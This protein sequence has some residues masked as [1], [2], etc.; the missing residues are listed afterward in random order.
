MKNFLFQVNQIRKGFHYLILL[1]ITLSLTAFVMQ[2]CNKNED[3]YSDSKTF[4]ND[5]LKVEFKTTAKSIVNKNQSTK[6]LDLNNMTD[7]E[8]EQLAQTSLLLIKS[9]GLTESEIEVELEGITN[10]KLIESAMAIIAIEE[11]ASNNLE[12]IDVSDN[13]SLLTGLSVIPSTN[14]QNKSE[15]FHCAMEAIG[16]N[17]LGELISNGIRD[18]PKSAVKKV[19]KK[20]AS[21]YLG[22]V[23]AAIAIY[24]FGDCMEWW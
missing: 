19:L 17:A 24:E 23:G 15:I 6:T 11:E 3:L 7:S 12:L 9:Y 10:D 2:S 1:M 22:Y 18:M 13:T 21:K 14:V 20:V 16:I 4:N 8:K 5:V